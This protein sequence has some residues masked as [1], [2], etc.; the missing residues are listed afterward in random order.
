VDLTAWARASDAHVQHAQIRSVLMISVNLSMCTDVEQVSIGDEYQILHESEKNV[1]ICIHVQHPQSKS[2]LMISLQYQIE[3][4][5]V[6]AH[7]CSLC[8]SGQR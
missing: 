2:V 6:C 4:S 1:Y 3:T 8:T 7:A 5:L